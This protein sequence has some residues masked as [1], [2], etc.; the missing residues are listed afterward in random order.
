[1][2]LN[3]DQGKMKW[4][5]FLFPHSTYIAHLNFVSTD[6]KTRMQEQDRKIARI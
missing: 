5:S 1:M 3:L 6:N 4:V 2:D